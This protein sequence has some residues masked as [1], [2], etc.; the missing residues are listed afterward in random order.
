M[1]RYC[2][3]AGGQIAWACSAQAGKVL[4]M[5]ITMAHH[6]L[7]SAANEDQQRPRLRLLL[8][9][10]VVVAAESY[11]GDLE[12]NIASAA[13]LVRLAGELGHVLCVAPAT[14]DDVLE[15]TDTLRRRQRLEELKKFSQ[16]Q[17]APISAS[18]ITRAGDS[19]KGT[20]DHRDLRLLAELDAGAVHY[21]VTEDKA[22]YKR[23][24]RA[25][26]DDRALTLTEA[27]ELLRS[28]L[29]P[30]R[31][32]PPRVERI[33][34]YTIDSDD[35]IFESLR[36]DYTEF[37]W[38]LAKVRADSDNRVCLVI[39]EQGH[40]AGF[41]LLKNEADCQHDLPRPV[42]KIS[43]FKV[44][45][46]FGHSK[47]G[48]LLLKAIFSEVNHRGAGALYVE[49][50]DKQQALIALLNNFGFVDIDARTVRGELVLGKTLRPGGD[51]ALDDLAHHIRFGP[52]ALLARQSAFVVPIW[53][54]WHDQLFPERMPTSDQLELFETPPTHPW[55][56]ALRKA[57]LCNSPTNQV[58]AGDILLFY[59]SKG[60]AT[61][62][63]VGIVED[64]LR[65]SDPTEVS[66]FVGIR[67]VYT[68]D[69]VSTM[70]RRVQGVL[71]I[72]FRQ[73]RFLEPEL[74]L[75]E[76]KLAGVLKAHPQAIT[77]IPDGSMAWL[78]ERLNELL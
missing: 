53:P 22:F 67:T 17:E 18:L 69:E 4:V 46:D 58:D 75:D 39:K 26:L 78:R 74:D 14:R 37:D 15:G 35:P 76:L 54:Q 56:N 59:R 20:N 6:D 31:A 8:D 55:G 36:E 25:G 24:R 21:L 64:T 9:S 71:A 29:T 23:C 63:A 3:S 57:Y 13:E 43:T 48:E 10:N 62:C 65:S 49:V 60:S 42:I 77:R 2:L 34:T 12:P 27:L 50:F 51:E 68:Y 38:W 33:P 41:V 45:T 40:Y 44:G 52:P 61:I 11:A 73:D 66:T 7:V 16:L 19:K 28:F 72:T 70:C 1:R 30:D 5:A 47:L 32:T